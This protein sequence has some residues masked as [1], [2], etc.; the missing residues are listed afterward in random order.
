V[1]KYCR[2]EQATDENIAH[3]HFILATDTY[4]EYAI[5]IAC[6][7]QQWLHER[8][9]LLPYTYIH[10]LPVLLLPAFIV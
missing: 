4:S 1:E 5:L 6:P 3:A 7:L 2:A 9:P 8:A 10:T